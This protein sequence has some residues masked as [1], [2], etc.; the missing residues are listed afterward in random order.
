MFIYITHAVIF[1]AFELYT[2]VF[3]ENNANARCFSCIAT[4][5]KEILS[6]LFSFL[7]RNVSYKNGSDAIRSRLHPM[8]KMMLGGQ[9]LVLMSGL[10]PKKLKLHEEK[11]CSAEMGKC[12]EVTPVELTQDTMYETSGPFPRGACRD[13]KMC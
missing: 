10:G 4:K 11:H 6:F 9:V 1:Y 5:T 3:L 2:L 13:G 12:A 8:R 7:N